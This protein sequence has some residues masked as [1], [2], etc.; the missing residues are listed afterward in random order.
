MSRVHATRQKMSAK[1]KVAAVTAIVLT[2]ALIIGGAFAWRDFSQSFLNVFRGGSTADALLHDDF[3]P[4]DHKDVYVENPGDQPIIV[5]VKFNEFFQVGN[6]A[7]VGVAFDDKE[8]YETHLWDG[9]DEFDCGLLTHEFFE[10][11]L[12]GNKTYLKGTSEL[13]WV[14]YS[15]E[16]PGEFVDGIFVNGDLGPNGQSFALTGVATATNVQNAGTWML[17]SDYALPADAGFIGWVLDDSADGN[18]WAYWSQ[19]LLPGE[20]TSLLLSN[21]NKLKNPEDNW[22]Y[23][24]PRSVDSVS[25]GKL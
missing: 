19:A 13:G 3:Q 16:T 12:G 1:K 2:L 17:M 6:E 21:V 11:V 23:N 4:W 14:D 9:V 8:T 5:R 18:G 22:N 15:G 7:L 24:I 10:W 20:A 25:Q